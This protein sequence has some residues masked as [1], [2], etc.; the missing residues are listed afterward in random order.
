VEVEFADDDLRRLYEEPEF[1]IPEVGPEL[2]KAFRKRVQFIVSAADRRDLYQ[3]RS[4]R[5]EKL[6]GDLQG[7]HSLRVTDQWRLIVR[8]E[9]LDR[10]GERVVILAMDDYH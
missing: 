2:T 10:G 5:F 6:K 7:E 8:L 3:M 1:R 4:N 9:Q